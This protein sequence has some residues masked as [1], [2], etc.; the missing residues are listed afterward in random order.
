[1]NALI[2]TGKHHTRQ[3]VKAHILLKADASDAGE[4]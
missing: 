4:G 3:L 1:V 2:R